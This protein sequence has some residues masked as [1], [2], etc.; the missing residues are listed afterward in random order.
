MTHLFAVLG[1]LMI[2]FSA[3]FVRL[4]DVS[5]ST[6]AFFRTAYALPVLG[7][8]CWLVRRRDRRR[9]SARWLAFLSGLL[10]A[11]DLNFWHRAIPLIGAG[12]STVLGNTQVVFVGL[13]AWILY[14]ERPRRKALLLV[15]LIIL[16]VVF[17]SGLGQAAAQRPAR[18]WA[19]W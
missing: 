5:A 8:L 14:G 15:L 10:L 19:A 2:S 16:G 7:I 3:I 9:A 12:L 13:A 11:A 4:A 17:I 18:P 6:A 1:T